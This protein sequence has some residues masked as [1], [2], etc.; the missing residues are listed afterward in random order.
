M[1]NLI[2]DKLVN[3]INEINSK[4]KYSR[5][6]KILTNGKI[7]SDNLYS[8]IKIDAKNGNAIKKIKLMKSKNSDLKKYFDD[9]LEKRKDSFLVLM[10]ENNPNEFKKLKEIFNIYYCQEKSNKEKPNQEESKKEKSNGNFFVK[11]MN[12]LVEKEILDK[13]IVDN[14]IATKKVIVLLDDNKNLRYIKTLRILEKAKIPL[15][16][17]YIK[18]YENS[19]K[20]AFKDSNLSLL[21]LVYQ[22]EENDFRSIPIN[23]LSIQFDNKKEKDW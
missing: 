1:K 11:Y 20:L 10:A 19:S 13:E 6:I 18:K 23:F 22:I 5:K 14:A 7:F 2:R 8:L 15:D 12:D 21:S 4:I 9:D 16:Y 3:K 17:K